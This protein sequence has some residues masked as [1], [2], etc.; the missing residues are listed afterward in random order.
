MAITETG[1]LLFVACDAQTAA[2]DLWPARGTEKVSKVTP[3]AGLLGADAQELRIDQS[4]ASRVVVSVRG[5]V[6]LRAARCT[7]KGGTLIAEV[8]RVGRLVGRTST[9]LLAEGEGR[10]R[11][12][13][14][15]PSPSVTRHKLTA[16]RR[17]GCEQSERER[18]EE[19]L[20]REVIGTQL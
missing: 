12:T 14:A 6:Q 17:G 8:L 9:V 20:Q 11:L 16:S 1:M 2:T 18:R 3:G 10:A 7:L 13:R 4:N 5:S 19:K 15:R